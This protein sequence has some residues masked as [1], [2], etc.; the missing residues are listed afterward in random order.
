VLDETFIQERYIQVRKLDER[1]V[2]W[3]MTQTDTEQIKE[4]FKEYTIKTFQ[5]YR[6][7]SKSYIDELL[8]M[9]Y[10]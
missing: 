9:N 10:L 4:I 8:I 6:S 7:S 1:N 5:V 2:K 3:L